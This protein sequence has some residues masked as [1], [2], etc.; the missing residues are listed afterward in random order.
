M[1]DQT[2][3]SGSVA[4][5][6]SVAL[7]GAGIA[8]AACAR[9]LADAGRRVTLLDKSRGVGGRMAVRRVAGEE[10]RSGWS[11][12][13]GAQYFTAKGVGLRSATAD[14]SAAGAVARWD[15]RLTAREADDPRVASDR[16]RHVGV[17]GMNG[18]AKHLAH[19]AAGLAPERQVRVTAV[20]REAGGWVLS[21]DAGGSHGP[22][23]AVVLA[24]PAPQ[25]AGVLGADHRWAE[26]LA[27]VRF[28]PTWAVMLGFDAPFDPGF[29]AKHVD[30]DVLAWAMR[31]D[32]K[33]GRPADHTRCGWTLHASHDWS[34]AHLEQDP[35][36]IVAPVADAFAAT[37][38]C[39]LPTPAVALAHRWRYAAVTQPL[40]EPCLW[41][42]DAQLGLCGD[43]C[44]G[45]KV[46][47]AY[48]SGAAL[49]A[50][51]TAERP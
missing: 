45:A 11:F 3:R 44:L 40:G 9:A 10:G 38:G 25:A 13:H 20:R 29:D 8:G 32:T 14:A 36:D 4:S 2:A 28:A 21:G 43:W 33:P 35:T 41:D 6:A 12:D 17:P 46:E 7:V 51:I 37:C 30:G 19:L 15:G 5:V 31:N 49:A 50:A 34:Q 47:A 39:P 18:L 22:F 26:R 1:G 16:D 23:D 48:D 42:A 24:I 27:A